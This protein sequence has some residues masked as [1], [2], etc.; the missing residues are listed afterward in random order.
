MAVA[1]TCRILAGFSLLYTF[2]NGNESAKSIKTAD[3]AAT[4]GVLLSR[5]GDD[6]YVFQTTNIC[7]IQMDSFKQ[8][9]TLQNEAM[10][11]AKV[12]ILHNLKRY[13]NT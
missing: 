1:A 12:E 9:K 11:F 6:D 5:N 3:A 8:S 13:H 4:T 2:Y 7:L 10:K